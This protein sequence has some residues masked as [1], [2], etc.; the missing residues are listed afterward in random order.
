MLSLAAALAVAVGL[1][2]TEATAQEK[3]KK[4]KQEPKAGAKYETAEEALRAGLAY[5]ELKENAKAQDP[6]EQALKL[7]KDDKFKIRVYQVLHQEVYR[8]LPEPD[9]ATEALEFVID[10]SQSDA[11][12]SL[13]RR[14]LMSFIHQRGKEDWVVNRYEEVLKKDPNNKTALYILSEVYA[15]LKENPKR[16][17]EVTERLAAV[18]KQEGGKVDVGAQA[19]LAGQYVKAGKVKEGAEIYEK[20]AELDPKMAGPYW[21]EAA[22]AWLKIKEK[23]K[24][25]AAAK[26]ANDTQGETRN[27][28]LQH[29]YHKALA[30]IF[31]ELGEPKLAIPHYEK[32][33]E[34]TNIAGYLADSKKKLAEARDKAGPDAAAE[35]E[36]ASP[37]DLNKASLDEL[38]SVE[39]I[40]EQIAVQI[41]DRRKTKPFKS[42]S[43]LIELDAVDKSLL[44]K[45][46]P[47][48]KVDA[49]K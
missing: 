45:I 22:A 49:E 37:I 13:A 27:D 39:G 6:L 18:T 41:I 43:E 31:L 36:K 15:R 47:H 21:K 1:A 32:A 2:A 19:N 3:A 25:L 12:R 26:A 24:A 28:L 48:V 17:A 5:L 35:T 9:K 11:E 7:A 8:A 20:I 30:D 46:R 34:K 42:V 38:K 33:I 14:S 10:K 44:A 4:G 40:N 29:F 16:A 23:E